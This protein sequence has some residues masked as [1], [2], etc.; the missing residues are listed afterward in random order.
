MRKDSYMRKESSEARCS[1]NQ[2]LRVG[3]IT[4]TSCMHA[5]LGARQMGP[6]T[7]QSY[8]LGLAQGNH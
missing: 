1:T 8:V 6:A 5:M 3:H 7:S 2:V 4:G